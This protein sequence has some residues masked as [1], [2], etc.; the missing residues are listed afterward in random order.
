MIA[1]VDKAPDTKADMAQRH[2]SKNPANAN[3][4]ET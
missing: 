3:A 4:V 2:V 1:S